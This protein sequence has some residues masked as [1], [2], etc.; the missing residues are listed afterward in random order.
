MDEERPQTFSPRGD[1]S[2]THGGDEARVA[3]DRDLEALLELVQ[4]R[5]RFLEDGLGAHGSTAVCSATL[6]PPSSR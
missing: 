4:E 5:P 2:A 3:L 1:R 6:P